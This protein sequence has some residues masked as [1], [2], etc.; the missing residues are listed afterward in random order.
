M[1]AAVATL[2]A[3]S[4]QHSVDTGAEAIRFP[5]PARW[6]LVHQAAR[7]NIEV[8]EYLPEQQA[9]AHWSDM[10]TVIV[11]AR[12]AATDINAFFD[13][14]TYTFQVGCV[15]EA[16]VD[17]PVYSSG[18]QHPAGTQVAICGRSRQFGT[19]NVVVY[20][21]IEGSSGFYQVQRAWNFPPVA[22][23]QDVEFSQA[24]R[25]NA[26]ALLASFNLSE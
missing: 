5:V 1:L 20:K 4:G 2:S 7:P 18:G 13:R 17:A 12:G 26:E 24:M 23:S 19:A 14:M 9:L 3:C 22:R 6:K 10:I 15:V 8:S 16:I 25:D 11:A 21:M